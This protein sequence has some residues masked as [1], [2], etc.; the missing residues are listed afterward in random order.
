MLLYLY[1][2]IAGLIQAITEFLPVSSSGH[3]II[4]HDILNF[5]VGNTLAFDVALH[6]GTALALIIYFRRDI[7]KY[8]LAVIEIFIPK[9]PVNQRDLKDV[10][11]IIYASIPAVIL[12]FLLNKFAPTMF[13][14]T[15]VVVVTLVVVAL[16]FFIVEKTAKHTGDYTGMSIG[17]AFYIGCAQA[18]ALIPGVS[19]S[20]ITIIAG[21]SADLKRS[22]AAKFSFL[23]SIPVVLGAGV[24]EMFDIAW[25]KLSNQEIMS[26]IVGFVVS[27]TVGFVVIKFFLKYIEHHKLNVF[28]WYRIGLALV[29]I[30]GMW[31]NK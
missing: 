15:E 13:R 2:I 9:R 19:R 3:L 18:L 31:L 28:G 27:A 30:I 4:L 11:L 10:M 22:E 20:G 6:L 14:Q 16:L 17:K 21:M 23:L 7:W 29:L 5:Q 24:L 1:S 25:T 12:G 8:I 26:I